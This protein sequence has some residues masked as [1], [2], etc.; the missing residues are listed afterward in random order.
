MSH[1]PERPP[2]EPLATTDAYRQLL[3]DGTPLI[4]VRA[5]VEFA[6]GALPGA[7]N[8]PLMDDDERHQVGIRYKQAGQ[9]KAIELGK[10]LVDPAKRAA[11]TEAWA[12]QL[13]SRPETL[14]Y[15][16]RGGLRSRIAQVWLAEAGA[17]RPLI[18]GGY[19]AVRQFLIAEL[20]RQCRHTRFTL[21]A[22]RTGS[23]KTLLLKRLARHVDLEG[24]ARHRGS[25]FGNL[26]AEQPSPIDVEHGITLAL[27]RLEADLPAAPDAASLPDAD[28][29]VWLEDEGKLIGRVCLP[30]TLR[31]AMARA[32]AVVLDTPMPVRIANCF[33]D[34][35]PDLLSRYREG[36]DP[37][38]GFEAY[39]EHHRQSLGRIRKRLGGVRHA[40][41]TELLEQALNAHR[42]HDDTGGYAAFIELLLGH[43]YDPMYD[44][45][46]SQKRRRILFRGSA[47]DI[48]AWSLPAHQDGAHPGSGNEVTASS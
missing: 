29:R 32:P 5:P 43:Y 2:S 46:L 11:R 16:F 25:S 10:R 9:D 14:V 36:R 47:E 45:Q 27:M 22:G 19:K 12:A 4:D 6:R 44:Y 15:C 13:R 21:L 1:A 48:L 8:L 26:G 31:E 24:I 40:Q 35:V 28:R 17:T 41:A 42:E 38:A 23:G 34:Y 30:P 37:A 20:E 3:L 7:I 33:E 18:D 39:A